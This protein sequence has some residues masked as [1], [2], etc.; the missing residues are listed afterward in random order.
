LRGLFLSLFFWDGRNLVSDLKLHWDRNRLDRAKVVDRAYL[1]VFL[2]YKLEIEVVI[3]E[4]D[5]ELEDDLGEGLAEADAHSTQEGG[6]GERRALA[7]IGL[8]IPIA[9]WVE[10]V[11]LEGMRVAPLLPIEL[12]EL[13]CDQE[14]IARAKADTTDSDIFGHAADVGPDG[15]RVEPH[16]LLVAH[17]D[18]L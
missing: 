7:T 2:L 15:G 10:P 16:G 1:H 11:R 12:D 4:R 13:D 14:R 6:V 18:I 3:P 9:T 17:F 5:D 8:L